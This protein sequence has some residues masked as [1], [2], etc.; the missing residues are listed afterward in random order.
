MWHTPAISRPSLCPGG[1]APV[2]VSHPGLPHRL[3]H[4]R[5]RA[6][7]GHPDVHRRALKSRSSHRA[8][9]GKGSSQQHVQTPLRSVQHCVQRPLHWR[10][11]GRCHLI[12]AHGR[13]H[14]R[15]LAAGVGS[16]G[17]LLCGVCTDGRC[18]AGGFLVLGSSVLVLIASHR[19]EQAAAPAP[20]EAEAAVKLQVPATPGT[21]EL[22]VGPLAASVPEQHGEGAE[23]DLVQGKQHRGTA[24]HV[25]DAAQQA[26]LGEAQPLV[27]A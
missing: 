13:L 12:N 14:P 5:Q 26:E 3:A 9:S 16:S 4:W 8:L 27:R 15:H 17:G 22:A 10:Q 2:A 1:A 21:V 20:L 19:R 23:A 18:A 11:A 7:A 24:D 6:A 25:E